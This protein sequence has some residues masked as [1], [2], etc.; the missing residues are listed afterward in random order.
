M[1][2]RVE[3]L[4]PS[5]VANAK[6]KA[7]P[8]V[9]R[10]GRGLLLLIETGGGR[11]W[12]FDYRRPGTGKRNTLSLG[13]YPDVSLKQARER[14]DAARK[15]LAEGIDP[16]EARK[17]VKQAK[18]VAAANTFEAVAERWLAT[19]D[20]AQVTASKDAWLLD[21][22]NKAFGPR[23]IDSITRDDV[24]DLLQSLADKNM[25]ET[26]RRLRSKLANVFL[27]S[28][29][30][31][32]V[33]ELPRGAIKAPKVT[34]HA[35]I[36]E[37]RK[38]GELLRAIDGYSG[39][40][41]TVAAL[42]LSPLLFVRPGELRHAEWSEID[43]DNATWRIPAA[44]MKMRA[45]HIVPLS[46]QVLAILRDLQ[47]MTGRGKYVFPGERGPSRPMSENTITAALRYLGF[48]GQ[49][50]SAHGFRTVASTLLHE[51]GYPSDVIERQLAHKERNA[52]KDA[53]NRAQHLPE[54]RTM[55]QAWADYL[56]SLRDGAS[57]IPIRRKA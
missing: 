52:I 17:A 25:L 54:R 37:P 56:D 44:K 13:T 14:R 40:P 45:E 10:D 30:R 4:S 23:P 57:V 20:V 15:L 19:R 5:A 31:N 8:Y 21:F 49:T 34:H 51:M 53:Y 1:P 50:M 18:E 7:E 38:V 12:R 47:P 6:P 32:P 29:G 16:G 24:R 39:Q 43:L 3:P 27:F 9:L 46:A 42:R 26:A 48:D 2:K 41:V 35:A 28:D 11:L 33:A 36:T 22:A 55:M